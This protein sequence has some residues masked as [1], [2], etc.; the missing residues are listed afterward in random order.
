MP[1][2]E[3][4]CKMVRKCKRKQICDDYGCDFVRLCGKPQCKTPEI[5]RRRRNKIR[6]NNNRR[7]NNM[8]YYA[9]GGLPLI[10]GYNGFGSGMDMMGNGLVLGK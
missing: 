3:V 8:D 5:K 1:K 7:N 6:R 9:Y 2:P 4:P 10:L